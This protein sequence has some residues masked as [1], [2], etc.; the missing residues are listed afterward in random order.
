MSIHC[1]VLLAVAGGVSAGM[2]TKV[3]PAT[4]VCGSDNRM[5]TLR[6]NVTTVSR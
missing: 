4:T 2:V 3:Q 6:Y 5:H 1:L